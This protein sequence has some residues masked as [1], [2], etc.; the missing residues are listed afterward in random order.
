[1]IRER[2]TL[3]HTACQGT[4]YS[5]TIALMTT[6]SLVL[7]PIPVSPND[8]YMAGSDGRIYSR[9]RYKGFGRKEL[10]DWY[11]LRG[12]V[13]KRGYQTVSMSHENAKVTRSVHRLICMAF[14][15]MPKVKTMQVRHLN[16]DP[17]DNRPENLRWGTA[18]EN[19]Q[20]KR[21]HG[22]ATTGEKHPA[23]KFTDQEKEHIRWA[24]QNG[25][26]SQRHAARVLG[27]AQSSIQGI[28]SAGRASG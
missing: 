20:D 6:G 1:M 28:L 12:F 13:T 24:I 11:P 2:S 27:V 14:H 3:A 23:S 18:A 15:G 9:T 8:D 21:V 16:G 26:C 4:G 19:W 7:K 10:V 25:L 22:R 5:A 17:S